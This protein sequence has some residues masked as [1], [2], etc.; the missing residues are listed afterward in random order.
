[1]V[2][3]VVTLVLALGTAMFVAL[4]M[5]YPD[6][7]LV[8]NESHEELRHEYI[9]SRERIFAELVE[10]EES[11][12]ANKISSDE[13]R[14]EKSRLSGLASECLTKMDSLV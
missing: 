7:A 1:M 6:C 5:F 4:P 14:A 9:Q 3:A 10:L 2:V 13:Y 8:N 11:K 12:A